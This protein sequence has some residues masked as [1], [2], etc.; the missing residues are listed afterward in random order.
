MDDLLAEF[1]AESREML[2]A[3][4]GEIVAWETDP[5][6]RARLDAIFRFVHTVKGNCGFFD[7][8]RLERLSHAAESALSD[9]RAEQRYADATL[10]TAVLAIIDRIGEMVEAIERGE[11]F[12]AG[13]DEDLI[14]ALE[15]GHGS[16]AAAVAL[17]SRPTR[18]A[19]APGAQQRS[20]RLPVELLD[21]VMSG[22]SDLVLARN[23]LSRRL[24]ESGTESTFDGPFER[25]SSTLGELRDA[26]TRM[27]MQRIETLYNAF[28]RLVRDLS[29]ELGKQVL[30]DFD[31]GTV[32]LDREMIEMIRDPLTHIVRNAVDHGVESPAERR[33]AGKDEAAILSMSARQSGNQ[34]TI[35][36][37]DDGRGIDTNKLG[38][39]A[40]EAG[41]VSKKELAE[42]PPEKVLQLVFEPGL[43]T[44]DKI[45]A[46]SGRGV[47]MDVV[48]S[49]IERVGGDIS[50]HSEPGSGTIVFL[51]VPLTL[52]IIGGLTIGV[53]GQRM[54]IPRSYVEEVVHCRS[55]SVEFADMGDASLVTF[56]GKRIRYLHLADV[57]DL[58]QSAEKS[59]IFIVF[60]LA[61]GALFALGVDQ[62]FDHEEIVI[63]PLPAALESAK[64]YAGI[65]LLDSG[66]PILLLDIPYLATSNGVNLDN[67]E[68]MFRAETPD[69]RTTVEDTRKVMIFNGLDGRRRAIPMEVIRR[70]DVVEISAL[71]I[72]PG[73]A[74]V[75]VDGR[76]FQ[77]AGHEFGEMPA[78]RLK[79]LR[80]SDGFSEVA[81]CA[82]ELHDAVA[83]T[84]EVVPVEADPSIEGVTLI[85]S[86]AVAIVD[87]HWLFASCATTG[88]SARNR[89]C[90][91]RGGDDWSRAILEPLVRAAGYQIAHQDGED[92]DVLIAMAEDGPVPE[93]DFVGPVIYLRSDRENIAELPESIFRYDREGLL[94]ALRAGGVK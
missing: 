32:E 50:L 41:I 11:D 53:A 94:N 29:A 8:P 60:K 58:D 89:S 70:I 10:V 31:G 13:G 85:G 38:M 67:H 7:F 65:T 68:K 14:E 46:I 54:A 15:E 28:P 33:A 92:A 82:L 87:V 1:V 2:Q 55:A 44:A 3:I 23:D 91:L 25:L 62:V 61:T 57:L 81:Y 56:R 12:P 24:R 27:R 71:D 48:R 84:D 86:E 52:S 43:S 79:L 88:K 26:V 66:Q 80:L 18:T 30:L 6:D 78:D 19:G 36:I 49:N 74:Q 40:V 37:R 35:T 73:R 51:R 45:S 39:K 75:I 42:M 5:G 64:A 22:V 83:V 9:V 69:G 76:I 90:R 4:E 72:A 93:G 34:I 17:T 16:S 47:G 77:L 21:R 20:I 59:E 63:K